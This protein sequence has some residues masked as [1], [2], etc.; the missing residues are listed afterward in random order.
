MG[1]DKR[2]TYSLK[3]V[4]AM[5]GMTVNYGYELAEN[6]QFPFPVIQVNK[7]ERAVPKK[8]VDDFLNK[9]KVPRAAKIMAPWNTGKPGR[10]PK[11]TPGNHI[12]WNYPIPKELNDKFNLVL[13]NMNKTLTSPIDKGEAIRLAAEEFVQRRPQFLF[14][15]EET[16]EEELLY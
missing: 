8:P 16:E 12:N 6:G 4:I 11:W 15:P 10:T 2:L 3:E 5:L 9:G 13:K 1:R 14:E 7:T